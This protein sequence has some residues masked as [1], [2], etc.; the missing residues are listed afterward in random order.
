[1]QN[2]KNTQTCN[3]CQKTFY[4]F[5]NLKRHKETVHL[6]IK[7]YNCEICEQPFHSQ[8]DIRKHCQRI[9]SKD[10]IKCDMCPKVVARL[11]L[12]QHMNLVHHGLYGIDCDY[13][14]TSFTSKVGMKKHIKKI[15]KITL[16]SSTY[17]KSGEES[18]DIDEDIQTENVTITQKE[19]NNSQKV[20][21]LHE[22]EN[23]T[24]NNQTLLN[25]KDL[26]ETVSVEID[27]SDKVVKSK[28]PSLQKNKVKCGKCQKLFRRKYY[29]THLKMVHIRSKNFS[30]FI[31]NI[32][33]HQNCDLN[34]HLK[35]KLHNTMEQKSKTIK[36]KIIKL[37]VGEINSEIRNTLD[38]IQ[39]AEGLI[40]KNHKSLESKSRYQCLVP[41]QKKIQEQGTKH[42]VNNDGDINSHEQESVNST[43]KES[44]LQNKW[45]QCMVCNEILKTHSEFF[46]H[47]ENSHNNQS[48][49]ANTKEIR[50]CGKSL[51]HKL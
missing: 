19:L 9:H 36:Q 1:M 49:K 20:N 24:F 37:E 5:S 50:N 16:E 47:V 40:L 15:H 4:K 29:N 26:N 2:D 42:I 13:C 21:D 27:A 7:K 51:T 39:E 45:L 43:E 25:E 38:Q 11:Y 8:A 30:C 35:T 22:T 48:N 46:E 17:A 23:M 34:R 31:C 28:N 44:P 41:Q 3:I 10:V 14:D 18:N 33:F 32:A 12:K 6:K